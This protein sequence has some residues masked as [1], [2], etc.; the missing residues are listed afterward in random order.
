MRM[1]KFYLLL[2]FLSINVVNAFAQNV[3][4]TDEKGA[5]WHFYL[6][7]DW[8]DQIEQDV[9]YAATLFGVENYGDDITVPS[10]V[11]YNGVEYPVEMIEPNVF[12]DNKSVT[13]IILPS[14]IKE[15]GEYAFQGCSSLKE[16]GDLSHLEYIYPGTF[17]DCISLENVD[18]SSCVR[19]YDCAFSG[20]Q[21]LQTIGS[22]SKVKY[23]GW[24][25][26]SSCKSLKIIDL[27]SGVEIGG[28]A[29]HNCTNLES[30]GSLDKATINN[31]AFNNCQ[32]LKS[33]DVSTAKK[34]GEWAFYYCISLE[35]VGD[36]S[37]FTA[38]ENYAF[39]QCWSL[40]EIDI[41][42]CKTIGISAFG[43]CKNLS[44]VTLGACLSMAEYAFSE[45]AIQTIDL[46]TVKTI[47]PRA[48]ERCTKLKSV[49]N[50]TNVT[51]IEDYTFQGC[52]SL[53]EIDLSKI[54]SFGNGAFESC[55]SLTEIDLAAC[56]TLGTYAFGGCTN[57]KE[58]KNFTNFTN[59][60]II[61]DY[62]F[63]GC[64]SLEGIDL[65]KIQSIGNGAFESCSSLTEVNLS[66]CQTLGTYAFNGC[67]NLK[68]VKN[69]THFTNVPEGA[70]YSCQSLETIDLSNCITF[71]DNAFEGCRSLTSIGNLP[72]CESIGTGAFVG[73][74]KLSDVVLTSTTLQSIGKDAFD[75]TGTLTLMA[76]TPPILGSLGEY[77]LVKVPAGV[78]ATYQA[79]DGWKDIATRIFAIGDTFS[80][81][82]E[83]TAQDASS[84]I[85][86]KI[87]EE[88]LRKVVDLKISGTINSYDI[89][90][91]RNKMPNL[92][93][94]DL[95]DARIVENS[96]E[97]YT[98]CHSENDILGANCFRDLSK[99]ITVKLPNTIKQIGSSAF[100]DC[101]NLQSI[102]MYEGIETINSMAFNSCSQLK[103]VTLP[104]GLLNIE[105]YAF[106][107]CHALENVDFPPTLETIGGDVFCGCNS[108]K[109]ISLPV[110]LKTIGNGAFSSCGNLREVKIPSSITNIEDRA[111]SGCS[112][113]TKVYTYTI[114]P[115]TI[116][117][118]TFSNYETA[119]L[120]VPTTSYNNYYWDTEWS[121]FRSLIEF[122][123]P[124]TYFYINKDYVLDDGRIDGAPD[125]DVNAGGS[126]TVEGNEDQNLGDLNVISDGD[127]GTGAS[128]IADDNI[129][130]NWLQ[131]KIEVNAN[132]WYFFSFPFNIMLSNIGLDTKKEGTGEFVFRY[133]DGAE[134]A[135]NGKGGWK[136]LPTATEKLQ[137]GQGYILQCNK[138]GTLI[139]KVQ[140]P[141]FKAENESLV[142]TDYEAAS[143]QD[144]G[145]NFIGNP[146]ISYYD[147][148]DTEYTAPITIWNGTSY[149]AIRPADDEY[150]FHPF[151]A[152]FVQKPEAVDEMAFDKDSRTTYLKSKEK[153]EVAATRGMTR[154]VDENRQR[155]ELTIGDT[156]VRDKT[157]IV[158]NQKASL[159]YETAC[160]AAKFLSTE[161]VPQIYSLDNDS[162]Y[163]INER[164]IGDVKLG[165][166]AKTAG[167]FKIGAKRLDTVV[168]LYDQVKDEKFDLTTGD[169]T[170]ETEA[171]TFENRFVVLSIIG[172]G[173]ET[174]G[175]SGGNGDS[176]NP[177]DEATGVAF[178]KQQTGVSV[179]SD[180]AG[181]YVSGVGDAEVSIYAMS[182]TLL[183]KNVQDGFVP[184]PKATYIVKVN[185][186]A[187]KLM[188][189]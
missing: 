40:T 58:V 64:N 143:A 73:C 6:E 7:T 167:T 84:G 83:T 102:T 41:S 75:F 125:A 69:F 153:E 152:F 48:F 157:R 43:G 50:L 140:N 1:K 145:W 16:I 95:T 109:A 159:N 138:K 108:L 103:S 36:I 74:V 59:V 11:T 76:T 121:Q 150:H 146:Y 174:G 162:K 116:N 181:I 120:Y 178:V 137:N 15:I 12:K 155:I 161:D 23:L 112:N 90:I 26:F 30:V 77:I 142:L 165:Y 53:E 82:F 163:A 127:S 175:I 124:Y 104:N 60:T 151:Q 105:Y 100:Y 87:G 94:L 37:S 20:C 44:K 38:F 34:V 172:G 81:T 187:T 169:Y 129:N 144:A 117:Q 170:F 32:A 8:D 33:V 78:L 185:K 131:F 135:N 25:A 92:H 186:L 2:L 62:T 65:S 183:A 24:N 97:Y 189:K 89:M 141:S 188:V 171:G 66:A 79:A 14:S 114:E 35:S 176:S 136:N 67:T 54:Q 85:H 106:G 164:P 133:Y 42:S 111:F 122:D 29:F 147:I 71:G 158:F 154:G 47:G 118:N 70:F 49:E 123:E 57:L 98:G 130:A 156:E 61:E 177:E 10:L 148:N 51:I 126:P 31:N 107:Y 160:D 119:D 80:Y 55:R 86:E 63:Q 72:L 173:T 22:L 134:R 113:L 68:E 27:S 45:T 9:P 28:Y 184:L 99:L 46:S 101:N 149:E 21:S 132:K 91:I 18:L 93:Y 179:M 180:A 182:G 52:N 110:S 19:I 39:N 5:V 128:V 88:N 168:M 3:N 166:V 4:Y 96:Y 17:Q 115:T 56:Q 13:R 139:L